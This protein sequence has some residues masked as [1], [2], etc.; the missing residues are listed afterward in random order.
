MVLFYIWVL[1]EITN[2]TW[3]KKNSQSRNQDKGSYRINIAISWIALVIVFVL[4]SFGIGI[5]SGN[6]QYVGPILL[7]AGVILREWSIWVLGKYFT[8]RVQV[9]E[10]AKLLTQGPYKYIRHPSIPE[11]YWL[12]YVFPYRLEPGL[13]QLSQFLQ[14]GSQFNTA[15]VL[16]KRRCKQP[17]VLNMK[18]TKRE[19]GRCFQVFR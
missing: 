4:R 13:K 15:S 12:F 19:H 14:K 10:K 8:V 5:F 16:K 9:S 6:L 2:T 3:S 7:T 18:S 11:F 17:F 1:S